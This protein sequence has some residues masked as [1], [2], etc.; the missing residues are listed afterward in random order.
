M[1]AIRTP[2]CIYEDIHYQSSS[3]ITILEKIEGIL[4]LIDFILEL[5]GFILIMLDFGGTRD[6]LK[7]QFCA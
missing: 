6:F 3:F 7:G 1:P 4:K 5:I 2:K